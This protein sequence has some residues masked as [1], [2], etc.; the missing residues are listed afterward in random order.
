MKVMNDVQMYAL[1]HGYTFGLLC[2]GGFVILMC[3]VALLDQL[4]R[5]ASGGCAGESRRRRGTVAR[6]GRFSVDLPSQLKLSQCARSQLT[7]S[8]LGVL[9]ARLVG[10]DVDENLAAHRQAE[11]NS[12]I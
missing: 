11:D 1:D 4:H 6:A 3:A 2:L 12:C 9:G 8:G 5:T 10:E 7:Q